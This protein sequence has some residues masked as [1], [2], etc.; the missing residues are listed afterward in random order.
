MLNEWKEY[1]KSGQKP[2]N[3][4]SNPHSAYQNKGWK[5]MSDW[6]GTKP[7]FDGSYLPFE[8]A[9]TIIQAAG[10][11]SSKDWRKYIKSGSKSH[12][13]PSTPDKYYKDKG[14]R[15]RGERAA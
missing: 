10:I 2:D 1:A 9:K 3:I 15:D 8:E 11:K 7:D 13:I 4:P 14:W 5:T 6:L 12:N